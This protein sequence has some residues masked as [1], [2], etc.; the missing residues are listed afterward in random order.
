MGYSNIGM[1]LGLT[2]QS[3]AITKEVLTRDEIA[4]ERLGINFNIL[5]L[6]TTGHDGNG[7]FRC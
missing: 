5:F 4:R 2:N 6:C 1:D 7:S 3:K